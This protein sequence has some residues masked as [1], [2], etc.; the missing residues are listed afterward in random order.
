M[1][2]VDKSLSNKPRYV[3]MRLMQSLLNKGYHL[4]VDNYYCCPQ[5]AESLVAAGTMVCG[6][7]RSNIVGMPR[8]LAQGN[9]E[10]GTIDYR[11]R[12]GW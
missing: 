3:V 1:F 12:G 9:L 7:V 10:K 2:C 4:Y 5:L 11:R 8:E 6:T